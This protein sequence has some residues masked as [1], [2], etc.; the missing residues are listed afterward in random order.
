MS[1]G[2]HP[3]GFT[4]RALAA[5]AERAGYVVASLRSVSMGNRPDPSLSQRPGVDFKAKKPDI[6]AIAAP[7]A[8]F[9]L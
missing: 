6:S 3:L 8:A 2:F 9:L 1:P 7:E 4:P 5:A